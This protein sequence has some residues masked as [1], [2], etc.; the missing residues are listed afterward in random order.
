MDSLR[1]TAEDV[2]Q[3]QAE[4]RRLEDERLPG[5]LRAF[6]AWQNA[7]GRRRDR[8]RLEQLEEGNR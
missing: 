2:E 5:R 6:V 4:W 8:E 7:V 3:L 1:P